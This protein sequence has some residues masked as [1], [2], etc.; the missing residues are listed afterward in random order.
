MVRGI[1]TFRKGTELLMS[2]FRE[3]LKLFSQDPNWFLQKVVVI[4]K[5]CL[6]P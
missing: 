2:N 1:E 4:G 5:A 6:H 3:S